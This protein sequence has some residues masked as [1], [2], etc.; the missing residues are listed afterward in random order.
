MSDRLTTDYADLVNIYNKEQNFIRQNDSILPVIH[1]AWLY[2]KNV[3]IID[4]PASE[5]KLPEVINTHF[6]ELFSSYQTSEVY[7]N[8]NIRVDDWKLN[9]EK[10][11]FQIFSGRTTYYKSLVTNR[12]MDYVLSNGASVRKMLEGGPVIHSL[13]DS[14]LSNHLGFNGFIET[15]DEKFMFVFRKK[16]VSIGEGTYS[17]SVAASLKTK[18]AL[19]PSSQFTMAGLENGIIREIED[20]LGIPPETLLRD[21]NNILSGPIKLI[22]AYRDLLEGGKPQLL[23]YAMTSMDSKQVTEVF[24]AKNNHLLNNESDSV[25]GK[26]QVMSTDGNHLFWV[27][28][29]ELISGLLSSGGIIHH[30][31]PMLPSASA[32]VSMLQQFLKI[33]MILPEEIVDILENNGFSCNGKISKQS[34]EY[35]V[36][37][38]QG[39][40]LGEDWSEIIWF[41]GSKEGFVEAVRKRANGFDVDEEVEVYIPCR[42]E[43]GCP[44][45][46]EDLVNDAKWKKEQ[47][48]KLADALEGLNRPIPAEKKAILRVVVNYAGTEFFTK[49]DDGCFKQHESLESARDYII[50]E[51]GADVEI[52]TETDVRFSY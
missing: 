13:K 35:Y 39:T 21:K 8:M 3:E 20:E 29:D 48:E 30:E 24:N 45:S 7:D 41:D 42:G 22:A 31:L 11:L 4:A 10:N 43:N 44:S 17:N 47:I 6:D 9:S 18:Y 28:R 51:Y 19:N 46:I 36:E 38:S 16:G 33:T 37:I 40:P 27:S 14:S 26:K 12:A 34:G 1:I 49:E 32:C 5:Y 25:A 23:F 52:E 2:N 50:H 15:S